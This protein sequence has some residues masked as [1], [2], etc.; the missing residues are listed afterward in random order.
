MV[1]RGLG[2]F[3]L[4]QAYQDVEEIV[5]SIDGLQPEKG[6]ETLYVVRELTKKRV[7][8][9]ESLISSS[10]AEVRRLIIRA[11]EWAERL[12]K[13]VWVWISDKQNAFLKGIAAN[14]RRDSI[15]CA[16]D[17]AA[18]RTRCVSIFPS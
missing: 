13:R 7:W 12:G 18:K 2:C 15:C 17:L 3:L 8:F 16:T 5:L 4:A 1:G 11:R 10:E 14:V 9:A 6:H